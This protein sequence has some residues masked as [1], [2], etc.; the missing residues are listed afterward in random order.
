M[1]PDIDEAAAR[2]TLETMQAEYQQRIDEITQR[3][4]N[5]PADMAQDWSDQAKLHQNDD[6][7]YSLKAE[8]EAQLAQVRHALA[9]LD[10]GEYGICEVSGEPIEAGRL[11]AM[12][13]A[14]RSL[15][16]AD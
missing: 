15:K 13:Q 5:P 3:M 7:N 2:S 16:Y 14:T 4:S 11:Q 1:T 8:A 6:A 9:R 12:P 10:A